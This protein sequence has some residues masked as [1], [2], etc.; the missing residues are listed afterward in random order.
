MAEALPTAGGA[1]AR[2]PPEAVATTPTLTD[3]VEAT[4]TP[5]NEQR[6]DQAGAFAFL[7]HVRD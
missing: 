3:I 5:D 4:L 6:L 1:L 2:A 7:Y